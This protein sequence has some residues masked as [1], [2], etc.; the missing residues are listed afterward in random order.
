V[1]EQLCRSIQR[2]G[3]AVGE[4]H[5]ARI[6]VT[7]HRGTP[8]VINTPEMV[9]LARGAARAVLGDGG[10][11]PLAMPNM[12]GEDFAHYLQRVPGAYV[13]IGGQA[14][15]REGFPAHSSRFDFDETALGVGAAF[16]AELAR[17]AAQRLRAEAT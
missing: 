17:R 7:I 6:E 4:L 16:M 3:K 9:E 15:G 2:I 12:G 13:R 14:P 8:A 1:R 11:V 5:G 10:A